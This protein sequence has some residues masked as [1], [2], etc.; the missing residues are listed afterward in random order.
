MTDAEIPPDPPED[1]TTGHDDVD[2]AVRRL[3]ELDGLPVDRHGEVLDEVHGRLRDALAAA[4]SPP[5]DR[6]DE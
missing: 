4:A 5:S 6:G 3:R 2:A 1:V